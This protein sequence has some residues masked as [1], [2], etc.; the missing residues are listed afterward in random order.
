MDNEIKSR[1]LIVEDEA[2]T[3]ENLK[4]M[5]LGLGH[6][7]V[8]IVYDGQSAIDLA[9][10]E[11]PDLILMDISLKGEM[12]GIEAAARIGEVRL[13]PVVFTTA[14]A[15]EELLSRTNLH[16]S[17]GYLLKPFTRKHLWST[18]TIALNK[19]R[20]DRKIRSLNS[21]LSS[22]RN[23]SRLIT[24][25]KNAEKLLQGICD[26]LIKTHGYSC[27][28]ALLLDKKQNFIMAKY[29][30]TL[31]NKAAIFKQLKNGKLGNCMVKAVEQTEVYIHDKA[32]AI[33]VNCPMSIIDHEKSA[34]TVGLHHRGRCY[35]AI[36]ISIPRGIS[37]ADEEKQLLKEIG[38]DIAYALDNIE[39]QRKRREMSEKL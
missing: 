27:V 32:D 13:T 18:L 31:K 38:V 30:G 15:N 8:G 36:C 28:M 33:C 26:N 4:R 9:N 10:K 23:V 7:V 22:I 11:R 2:I 34:M 37:I 21:L 1:I 25:Q 29:A 24:H 5:L 35:G 3:A 14:Y 16:T 39:E 12:D 19:I 6:K 17:Y 20:Q